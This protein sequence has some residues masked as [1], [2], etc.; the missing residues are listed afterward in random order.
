MIENITQLFA[1]LLKSTESRKVDFKSDQYRLD[2]EVLK[3]QFVKDILCMANAKGGEGYVILGVKSEKGRPQR[4]VG[5]SQ[6]FDSSELEAIVNGIIDEPIQF[7]YYALNYQSKRCA[8]LYIPPS[9]AKP[10]WPKKDYGVLRKHV[11]Y[12][13]RSSANREASV[14]EIREMCLETIRISD[15][16]HRKAQWSPHVVDELA[17]MSLDEREETM[18]KMLKSIAPKIGLARYRYICSP[19][20]FKHFCAL[21]ASKNN[22]VVLDYAI[23]MYPWSARSQDIVA[24]RYNTM[25]L[26][27]STGGKKV[28]ESTRNRLKESTLVHISYKNINTKA[29][30]TRAYCSTGYRFAN[31]WNL[32]WGRVMKWEDDVPQT[33]GAK[34]VFLTK[35]KYEFFV[36]NVT[37]KAELRERFEN[38]LA[39]VGTN[40]L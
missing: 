40:I 38:L 34:I 20:T 16:A 12:T 13:R 6:H 39:W 22:K 36:P 18:H 10:H 23:F 1:E 29:L 4:V 31:E 35:A 28:R 7:E 21:V 11:I 27:I 14:Q 30:E 2:N 37:S 3:S 24:A 32:P 9:K 33:N 25:R 15:I 8:L 17:D 26:R 19:I 5:I